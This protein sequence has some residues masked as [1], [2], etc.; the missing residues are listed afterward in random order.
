M[1]C[2]KCGS[3]CPDG[4]IFCEACGAELDAPVLPENIDE[5]GRVKTQKKPKKEKVKKEKPA[6]KQRSS[7]EK[8]ALAKKI[9]L[10][11]ICLAVIAV[12]VIIVMLVNA[13]SGNEGY[14]A[15]QS[16]PL[17]RDVEYA[18]SE[19]GL[20]F[21]KK[22]SNGMINSMCDFD[23]ICIS[24]KTT[25]VSG[26]EQPQWVIMLTV[27]EDDRIT[28]VEYYDFRQLKLNWK[29]RKMASKLDQNSLE[30]G[31]SI[32]N[33]SKSLG[34]KPYYIRRSV[35]NDSL[36]CYRY[37][38][39]DPDEGYDRSFNYYVEFSDIELAV[40]K[41]SYREINYAQ[42][43]LAAGTSASSEAGRDSDPAAE[44]E[45]EESENAE[46]GSDAETDDTS[47]E[48]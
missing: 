11:A 35:S 30:Y 38:Y 29:G 1:I 20:A 41:V 15:A 32:K 8:A 17:G 36:Y 4:N 18:R 42:T 26:S 28:D 34:L 25:T 43:I 21:E 45:N 23:Y 7:E 16:I 48:Q 39:T 24:E 10:G 3:K 12:I 44:A 5:K 40:R 6:R 31:M 19:T 37:F 22:S 46:E 2:K 9:K 13:F 33:V 27:G 47:S 14:N